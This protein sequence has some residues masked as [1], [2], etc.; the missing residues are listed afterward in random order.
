MITEESPTASA[1][2]IAGPARTRFAYVGT[3]GRVRMFI[4]PAM[5]RFRD[6]AE[7]VGL[8]DPSLVRAAFHQ[9]RIDEKFG[10]AGVPIYS[11][12]QFT[13]MLRDTRPDRVVVCTI[14]REHDTWIVRA[15]EAGCDVVTEKPMTIDAAKCARILRRSNAQVARCALRSTTAGPP[16]RQR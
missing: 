6:E 16:A 4:D 7:V 14:D 2:T 1:A 13:D 11:D 5:E 3:G 15:L 10:Q 12:E 8:C 9:K